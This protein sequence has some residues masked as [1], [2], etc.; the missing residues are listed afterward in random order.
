VKEATRK[1][2]DLNATIGIMK[3]LKESYQQ[4]SYMLSNLTE[5]HNS[6]YFGDPAH[7]N[8]AAKVAR[9]S[10]NEQRKAKFPPWNLKHS[11][12]E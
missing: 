7:H 2:L 11:K 3:A 8:A 10:M 9:R 4:R 12:E 1:V 6:M 5:L